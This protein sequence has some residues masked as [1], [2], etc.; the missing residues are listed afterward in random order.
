MRQQPSAKTKVSGTILF[1]VYMVVGLFILD[2]NGIYYKNKRRNYMKTWKHGSIVALAFTA[3]DDGNDNKKNNKP[4]A[5]DIIVSS[6]GFE[7]AYIP[8]G[9]FTMGSPEEESTR[10]NERPQHQA[11][12]AGFYIGKYEVTQAQYQTVMATNPSYFATDP[13]NGET[14]NKR[15]AEQV[16]WYDTLVFCNKLS[17]LEGLTP[18]YSINGK[19]NPEEW[20]TVPTNVVDAIWNAVEIVT[21]SNGYRLPTEAQWEYACRAGTTTAFNTGDTISDNTG[22]YNANSD[23]KTH[24]VGKKT[25]NVWGLYD[26]HGNVL[27]WCWDRYGD[28]TN[29]AQTNP[30]G[31][32]SES[33]RVLRGGHWYFSAGNVRSAFRVNYCPDG[34][35]NFIGFRLARPAN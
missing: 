20:G 7:L 21:G 23:S 12:L 5:G 9:T 25:A 24:E 35:E 28:Y 3:C 2:T 34:R 29:E 6:S 22:W 16:S 11:T 1:G 31:A 4:K 33:V 10:T 8:D 19:T 18:A 32:S 26:M 13:A 15:P 27:E 17:L 14:Q 30:G